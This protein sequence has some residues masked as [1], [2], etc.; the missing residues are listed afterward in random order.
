MMNAL[1]DA[2]ASLRRESSAASSVHLLRSWAFSSAA[3]ER[4]LPGW[5]TTISSSFQTGAAP[6]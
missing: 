2:A 1:A 3:F 5:L 4:G 6:L